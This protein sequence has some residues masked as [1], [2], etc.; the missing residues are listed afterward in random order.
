MENIKYGLFDLFAYALPGTFFLF[1]TV[2]ITAFVPGHPVSMI[3]PA[4]FTTE[5]RILPIVVFIALAYVTGFILC[6]MANILL[7][8]CLRMRSRLI[9]SG[10]PLTTSTGI[11]KSMKYV[12]VRE[13]AKENQKSI[14]IWNV[15]KNFSATVALCLLILDILYYIR[16]RSFGILPLAAG[17]VLF[18]LLLNRAMEYHSWVVSDLDNAYQ[19][20]KDK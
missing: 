16:F 6:S 19:K 9:K 11:T 10:H 18:L 5:Y 2:Y 13:S 4:F 8:L 14:E 3:D 20:N 1:C 15:M 12:I 7:N 17:I